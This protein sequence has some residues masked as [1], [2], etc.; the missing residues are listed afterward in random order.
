MDNTSPERFVPY[1]SNGT[2]KSVQELVG[3]S[4]R[5]KFLPNCRSYFLMNF[6]LMNRR[7]MKGVH[8]E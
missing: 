8:R 1:C 7:Q 4:D 6:I 2:S 5:V 3:K